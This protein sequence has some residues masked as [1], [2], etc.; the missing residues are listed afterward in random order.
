LLSSSLRSLAAPLLQV[1]TK[2]KAKSA[3]EK[4]EVSDL[5]SDSELQLGAGAYPAMLILVTS[6]Q[7]PANGIDKMFASIKRFVVVVIVAQLGYLFWDIQKEILLAD[8]SYLAL[9]EVHL[10]AHRYLQL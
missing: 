3:Q 8:S 6:T 2:Q 1:P 7:A 10:W 5:D 4:L 9:F